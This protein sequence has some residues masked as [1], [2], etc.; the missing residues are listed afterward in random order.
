MLL[1]SLAASILRARAPTHIIRILGRPSTLLDTFT[2]FDPGL[3][4]GAFVH[5]VVTRLALMLLL[6]LHLR[7][8]IEINVFLRVRCGSI[9]VRCSSGRLVVSC[10]IVS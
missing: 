10:V 4:I 5:L 7:C 9:A 8:R 2:Q 3:D 6:L 1:I